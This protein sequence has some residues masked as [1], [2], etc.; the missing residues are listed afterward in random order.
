MAARLSLYSPWREPSRGVRYL[1]KSI[2]HDVARRPMAWRELDFCYLGRA[3]WNWFGCG[4]VRWVWQ[5]R[6][7]IYLGEGD[8]CVAAVSICLLHVGL[9]QGGL[10]FSLAPFS[11]S[12]HASKRHTRGF[13]GHRISGLLRCSSGID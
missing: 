2:A 9:L 8:S 10:A 12:F 1:S 4:K 5:L 13:A 7:V 11:C 3:T 6:T